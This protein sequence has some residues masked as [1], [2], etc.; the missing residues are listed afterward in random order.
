MRNFSNNTNN[1]IMD[2]SDDNNG[3]IL[4]TADKMDTSDDNNGAILYT[5]DNVVNSGDLTL[6]TTQQQLQISINNELRDIRCLPTPPD[7]NCGLS[8]IVIGYLLPVLNN[9][10]ELNRRCIALYGYELS[11]RK[12]QRLALLLLK[13]SQS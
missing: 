5:A 11:S 8:T 7:G 6:H 1:R 2:T 3:A 10:I 13:Y 4:Y 9:M 12:L